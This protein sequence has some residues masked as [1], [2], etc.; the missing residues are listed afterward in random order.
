MG[1]QG[2]ARALAV[3]FAATLFA[4]AGSGTARAA[5]IFELNFWLK[6]PQYDAVVPLCDAP[7]MLSKIQFRF[8]QKEGRFWKSDL[9]ILGFE[10][11]R[12][13][14]FRPWAAGAPDAIP[15]RFCTGTALV[16]DGKP[17]AIHYS[18]SEDTGMI[19]VNWGV[20]WC[21]VGLDRNW[22]YNPACKLALP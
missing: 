2:I 21:V 7:S 14:S 15:R 4:A 20:E 3:A 13:I 9:K 16:S 10:R 18:I 8:A 6:G 22:A 5:S 17:R 12:E 19:G 1:G 11:I